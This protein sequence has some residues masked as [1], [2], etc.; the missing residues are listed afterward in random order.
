[1]P[2]E[3]IHYLTRMV[4]AVLAISVSL[5]FFYKDRLPGAFKI[6]GLYLGWNLLIEL[7]TFIPARGTNNLP[8]L[9]L[10]TLFEFILFTLFY[11]KLELFKS[12]SSKS[13]WIFLVSLSSLIILNSVFLQSIFAYNSYAKTIVQVLLISYSVGYMFQLK[14]KGD[15]SGSLNLANAAILLFYSGSLFVFM[16]G[17]VVLPPE[18]D[19]IFWEI[20]LLLNLLFQVL[21][22]VSL[23]KASRIRKLQF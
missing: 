3:V 5:A 9:H 12:W 14:E 13:F 11:K 18:Y 4:A 15:E 10:Y 16:F 17:N 21:I 20:N 7:V 8:L 6:L 22:L 2:P 1:M 19:N 23:W